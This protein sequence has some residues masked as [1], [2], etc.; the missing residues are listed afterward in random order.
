MLSLDVVRNFSRHQHIGTLLIYRDQM[1]NKQGLLAEWVSE[2][3]ETK[4]SGARS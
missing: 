3:L 2:H 1:D 4:V